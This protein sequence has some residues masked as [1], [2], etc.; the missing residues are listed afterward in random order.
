MALIPLDAGTTCPI[1]SRPLIP[2][3]TVLEPSLDAADISENLFDRAKLSSPPL[4][5]ALQFPFWQDF[6]QIGELNIFFL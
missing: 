2:Q 6:S 5:L 3:F 4:Y 1:L